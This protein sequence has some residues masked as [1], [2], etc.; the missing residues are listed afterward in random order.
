[1]VSLHSWCALRRNPATVKYVLLESE[2]GNLG[3]ASPYVDGTF[4]DDVTGIP[5][6]HDDA[7]RRMNLSPAQVAE[8]Q[9]ATNA[10]VQAAIETLA[11]SGKYIWQAFAAQDGVWGGPTASTCT[12]FMARVCAPQW[13]NVPWALQWDGTN[14]TL[15]AFLIG[16][17]EVAYIGYGWDGL[18]LPAWEPI[19]D[20]DVGQ[21][22][23]TCQ[24]TSSGVFSRKWSKGT[25]TLDCNTWTATLAF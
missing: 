1:M 20:T 22:V 2:Q 10:F 13:Q 17:G 12:A 24:Q 19:W 8:L 14:Q 6:E 7:P 3:T 21:P 9:N 23:Q 5:A 16:R 4:L 15:A 11:S 18:P 25:A